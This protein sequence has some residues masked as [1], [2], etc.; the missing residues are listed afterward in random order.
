MTVKLTVSTNDEIRVQHL[1]ILKV[2]GGSV[3]I[4]CLYRSTEQNLC[5][6]RNS[7]FKERFLKFET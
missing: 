6:F 4:N 7:C 3:E 2:H 5:S 1:S